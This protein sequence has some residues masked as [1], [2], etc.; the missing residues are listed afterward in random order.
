[1]PH[2]LHGSPVLFVLGFA[3]LGVMAYWHYR[4]RQR[5]KARAKLPVG[6]APA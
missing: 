4:T 3:P 1:M 6:A 5:K 2:W